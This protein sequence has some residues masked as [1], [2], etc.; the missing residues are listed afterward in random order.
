MVATQPVPTTIQSPF[1]DIEI[2]EVPLPAFVLWRAHEL[3]DKPALIDAVS[4]RQVSYRQLVDSIRRAAC[5]LHRRGFTKG[6]VLALYSPNLPEFAIA[7][8]AVASLGGVVTTINPLA[9]VDE[10]ASQLADSGARWLVSAPLCLD[11]ALQ[12]ADRAGLDQVYVFGDAA[13]GASAFDVLLADDAP[14]PQVPIDVHTDIIALPYSSGTT[15]LPKGVMLSQANLVANLAQLEGIEPVT[16]HDTLIA[17][18]PFFHIYG[19]EVVL[20]RGLYKGATLVTMPR[21]ELEPFLAALQQHAVTRAYLVPPIVLALA[22]HPVV[23]QYDLSAL[24]TIVGGAAQACACA[25]CASSL[26]GR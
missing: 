1:P 17:V 11:K 16:E 2:P 10:L 12:A 18:L 20:H 21:F 6:D 13:A 5:G 3:G 7:Y 25:L 19:M 26:V 24:K 4:G 15:G 23:E 22:K 9:T 14:L 8:Y